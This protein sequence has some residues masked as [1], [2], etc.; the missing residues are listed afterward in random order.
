MRLIF[1]FILMFLSATLLSGC[2]LKT[3]GSFSPSDDA[4]EVIDDVM[5]MDHVAD[6]P[7]ENDGIGPEC[8]NGNVDDGEDCD[9]GNDVNGDGCDNDCTFSCSSNADCRDDEICNGEET[10]DMDAHV[11]ETSDDLADGFVCDDDPRSI[12]LDGVCGES[13]CGDGFVDTG[14]G[15]FC[16]PPG[17]GSCTDDCV[18]GCDGPDDCPDDGNPC[19]GDEFCDMDASRCARTAALSDGDECGAD[20]RRICISGSCQ[21]SMCGDGFVDAGAAPAEECDDANADNG[22]GCDNDCTYSCHEDNDCDNHEICDGVETCDTAGT[23]ACLPGEN[24]SFGTACS[25]GLYCTMADGCDGEGSCEGLGNPCEDTLE[26]TINERCIE[27]GG[28][29]SCSFD[30]DSGACLIDEVCRS[31]GEEN[32]SNDCR[33]CSADDSS[34]SWTTLSDMSPCTG[35]VCCGGLCRT[36][37][38]CCGNEHCMEGCKGSARDCSEFDGATCGTQQGCT[39]G[40]VVTDFCYG[41]GT[42]CDVYRNE[43]DCEA[44]G[45]DWRGYDDSC[46]E[47]PFPCYGYVNSSEC[48]DCGCEW[49]ST[50]PDGCHGTGSTCS[51]F[52]NSDECEE[53]G[54]WW[55]ISEC[56]DTPDS[57]YS[58]DGSDECGKCGCDWGTL[59]PPSCTGGYPNCDSI[60]DWDTCWACGCWW[61]MGSGC[62]GDGTSCTLMADSGECNMCGCSWADIGCSGEHAAC[63]TYTVD[64]CSGQLDCYWSVCD[65]YSCT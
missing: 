38:N 29:Y 63:G 1:S 51:S 8:G 57:C 54:C 39:G 22:D 60:G 25:D 32:P 18:L 65:S 21:E 30:I 41:S 26:C 56:H 47:N 20:P 23:H 10:C 37:G 15:E 46:H 19:N 5:D 62:T 16:E 33:Y 17:E 49:G 43:S 42:E 48:G 11:C 14:G 52:D 12:C 55:G 4:S 50:P 44:C 31:N 6:Q 24:E 7:A 53:C 58:F 36:G 59:P 34:T 45:C 3:S 28:E 2:A 64:Q 35:G 40:S 9:D 13:V 27:G 61:D